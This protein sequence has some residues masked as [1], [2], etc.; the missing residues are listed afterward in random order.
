LLCDSRKNSF[1]EE[2]SERGKSSLERK[3]ETTSVSLTGTA[4]SQG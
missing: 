3:L 2:R 1:S 4:D